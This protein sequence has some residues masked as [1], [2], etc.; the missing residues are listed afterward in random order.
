MTLFS[1]EI[2]LATNGSEEAEL[3]AG[4][5]VELAKSRGGAIAKS[6][7][8]RARS[9]GA[10]LARFGPREGEHQA[11]RQKERSWASRSSKHGREHG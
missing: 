9:L 6:T 11:L 10:L 4:V 3:A 5:A 7:D 8:D 2:L 1:R